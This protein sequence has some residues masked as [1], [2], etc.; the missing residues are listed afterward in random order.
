MPTTD[1]QFAA[2]RRNSKLSTGPKTEAGKER[3]RRNAFK[4]GL[5]GEGIALPDEDAAEVVSR[6]R[7]LQA[8]MLPSGTSSMMLLRRFAYLSVRLERCERLDTAVYSKRIR[9]ADEDFL[10]HRLTQ[11]EQMASRINADPMTTSRRLRS[12]PEGIDW[13]I[14][15]W[16]E[17]RVDLMNRERDAWTH[18]HCGRMEDLLGR[19]N[20][21][22]F[23]QPRSHALFEV[24]RGFFPNVDPSEVEGLNDHEKAEWGRA[25]LA[26]IIDGEVAKLEKV[27]K[28]FDPAIIEQDRLEAA[29]RCLFDLQP[30]MNQVRKY[31]AATERAMYKALKEFRQ[32]EFELKAT[33]LVLPEEENAEGL[34]SFDPSSDPEE[35]LAE[36][37]AQSPPRTLSPITE[38]PETIHFP[39]K[40]NL[41]T[42]PNFFGYQSERLH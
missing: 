36:T 32:L 24:M 33:K 40:R 20:G 21:T 8:E 3:S 28:A 37:E 34:A 29:A 10:D 7:D 9:H 26:R 6:F 25:E 17:L 18:N 16:D 13:L 41:D 4:H 19:P 31:E 22:S 38:I 30:A 23:S 12:T 15:H 27:K 39:A 35:E 2:N 5:T 11:V 42:A 1:A 14:G